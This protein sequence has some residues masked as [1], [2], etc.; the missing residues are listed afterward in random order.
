[1]EEDVIEERINC[2]V[3]ATG[4]HRQVNTDNNHMSMAINLAAKR[5]FNLILDNVNCTTYGSTMKQFDCDYNMLSPSNYT[6]NMDFMFERNLKENAEFHIRIYFTP[7]QG[8]KAV[9]FLDLK[10]NICNFLSTSTS[11]PIIKT[12]MKEIRKTS[13]MPYECP[14]KVN[15]LYSLSNFSFSSKILP[16]Y[17]QY[18]KFNFSMDTYDSKK[19][20]GRFFLE[21]TTVRK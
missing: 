14:M 20:I 17:T 5:R 8:L 19:I 13:N 10:L 16:I 11:I 7:Q 4:W 9:K 21:G 18:I 6:L 1:M 12:I 3:S 2:F 15:Y